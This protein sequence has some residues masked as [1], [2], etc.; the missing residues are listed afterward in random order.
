M[1]LVYYAHSYRKVDTPVVEFFSELMRSEQLTASL[2]PPS[3]QL[4][5]A[6]P[7][8]HLKAT[9]GMIAVLT[10][11]DGGISPYIVYEISLCLRARKSLLL[12]FIEDV[13]PNGL[14]PSRVL[15]RRFSRKALLRQVRDHRHALR[16]FRYY[17]GDEPPPAYQPSI[18][19]RRCLL[20]GSEEFPPSLAD[21]LISK[22]ATRGYYAE[23]L[24]GEPVFRLYDRNLQESLNSA[25]LALAFVD[26]RESAAQYF[27][28]LLRG[29]F[30]PTILLAGNSNFQ[31]I[32]G[33]PTEYQARSID[34]S[35]FESLW[36]TIDNEISI[37]EEEYVDLN[38]QDQVQRYSELLLTQ[39]PRTGQYSEALRSV[40]VQE[41]N[42]GDQ[43]INYGQAGSIGRESTGTVVNYGAA[44][45]QLKDK[46]DLNALADELERLQNRTSTKGPDSRRRQSCGRRRRS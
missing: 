25:D 35:N 16:T 6:K 31:M 3:D 5:S 17:I 45:D 32:D 24:Q 10:A 18:E 30:V 27:V 43:N 22:L 8:R 40:F 19:K 4:N 7:E 2:D 11:R 36:S 20:A 15:Q 1:N 14:L 46:T 44:W 39:V 28:G 13:L 42:M 26:S 34:L 38:N 9:D 12:V 33:I 29:S 21:Q 41:L 37:S 23:L